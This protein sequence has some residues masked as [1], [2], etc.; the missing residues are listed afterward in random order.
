MVIKYHVKRLENYDAYIFIDNI[1]NMSGIMNSYS[2]ADP[3]QAPLCNTPLNATVN[4]PGSK[5]LSNRYLILAALS[6]KPVVLQGLLRS[7]DTELM[8]EALKVFGVTCVSLH[9][10]GTVVRVEP[11]E[12]G[13]FYVT[14]DAV[15]N[16]GLA[17][18]VM[19]FVAALTLFADKPVLFDG[20]EQAY[21]RPMKPILDALEQ[22]GAKVTYHGEVGFLPYTITPPHLVELKN[23]NVENIIRIDSSA[24]SQFISALLLIASRIPGGL[25]L[26]HVGKTL[27]SMPH[28]LMTIDDVQKAGGI[29]Q[30]HKPSSWTVRESQLV[31]PN[32]VV[33]EPDLS[34]AAPFLGAAL[35][36]GGTVRIPNWP[37]STTQ[38]GGLLPGILEQMGAVV[39][40]KE[41]TANSG[42][43]TLSVSANGS[44]RAIPSLDLSK[45]GEIAPSIAAIL[46]FADGISEL[47]GIAHLRGH[48]T[49]RLEALVAQLQRVGIGAQELE[50]GIRIEPHRNMHGEVM[51]SYA[52]HR[53][54]TFAAML[55]LRIENI[56]VKNIATTRKTIPDFPGM[57]VNM[58]SQ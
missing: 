25:N 7:R 51:E 30:M 14:S 4:I 58:I 3:W 29:V 27:P 32:A 1:H 52:D 15:I 55:G 10:D 22:L 6:K 34:N 26:N 19:R 31:L 18:T 28:I 24:S 20:D 57:W 8:I 45:A 11:N 54:A 49:N 41:N 38:P 40:F 12:D 48:E 35:I 2:C 50:D 53:M 46:A 39:T 13:V 9:N 44:I 36:S 42:S 37:K 43:G 23:R 21:A 16:C 47:H 17:G 33:V 5:S 56:R